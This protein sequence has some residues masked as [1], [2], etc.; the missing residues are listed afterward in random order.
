MSPIHQHRRHV[1]K[2]GFVGSRNFA[3]SCVE[4]GKKVFERNPK[5]GAKPGIKAARWLIRLRELVDECVVG[6]RGAE[7]DVLWK[8]ALT[9]S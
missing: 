8:E 4:M 5:P 7:K 2:G 1:A 3:V 9:L 6:D